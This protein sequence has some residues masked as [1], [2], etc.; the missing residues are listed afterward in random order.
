MGFPQAVYEYLT[1]FRAWDKFNRARMVDEIKDSLKT[2]V[3]AQDTLVNTDY[4]PLI[5]PVSDYLLFVKDL[6]TY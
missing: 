2:V 3:R 6:D 4:L 5:K 1:E